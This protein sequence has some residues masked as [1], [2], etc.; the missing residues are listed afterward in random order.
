MTQILGI[1]R[2]PG[3]NG[4][5]ILLPP[6]NGATNTAQVSGSRAIHTKLGFV[7]NAISY[8]AKAECDRNGLPLWGGA[9]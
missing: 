3:Y 2:L 6:V 1:A 7:Q 9:L 4:R 8:Y 5:K